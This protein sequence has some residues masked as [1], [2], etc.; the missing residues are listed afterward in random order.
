MLI[1]EIQNDF[2]LRHNSTPRTP[3]LHV[4]QVIST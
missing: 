2:S 3:G 4:S 1:E